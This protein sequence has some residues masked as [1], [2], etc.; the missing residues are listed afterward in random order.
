[1]PRDYI[2]SNGRRT[3]RTSGG[4]FRPTTLRDF[5]FT[6]DDLQT[7]GAVCANCG[8]TWH[9]ILKTGQCPKCGGPQKPNT[10]DYCH[11]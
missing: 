8:H 2:H 11:L 5:G 1:M 6:P 9:P 3:K 4:Q 10:P 7:T